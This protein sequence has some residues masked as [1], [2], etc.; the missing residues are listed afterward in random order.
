MK[1]TDSESYFSPGQA[2]CSINSYRLVSGKVYCLRRLDHDVSPTGAAHMKV[3]RPH[4]LS[5]TLSR[6]V[7][8]CRRPDIDSGIRFYSQNM[9]RAWTFHIP[10]SHLH[11]TAARTAAARGPEFRTHVTLFLTT[12]ST[13]M[14]RRAQ[15]KSLGH[16]L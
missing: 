6:E 16:E 15:H 2:K 11:L 4:V 14:T 13:K 5:T 10:V 1:P 9:D 7:V 12:S 8:S 3:K